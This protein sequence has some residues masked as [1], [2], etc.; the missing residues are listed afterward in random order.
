MPKGE[1]L[2]KIPLIPDDSE[3]FEKLEFADQI[4]QIFKK[5]KCADLRLKVMSFS[6]S[7]EEDIHSFLKMGKKIFNI[8]KLFSNSKIFKR[9]LE[10]ILAYGNYLNGVSNRGGAYAFRL[11]TF[12]KLI[13]MKSNDGSKSLLQFIVESI[14]T[15]ETDFELLNFHFELEIL[16]G[17][18]EKFVK[19]KLL[20]FLFDNNQ[21]SII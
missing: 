18:K 3:E 4:V 17:G 15:N 5:I 7:Y 11:D 19:K 6:L 12:N 14:G 9:W 20:S 21:K 13:E 10:Y 2:K 8:I 16:D 1:E